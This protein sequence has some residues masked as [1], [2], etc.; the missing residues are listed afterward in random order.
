MESLHTLRGHLGEVGAWVGYHFADIGP[1]GSCERIPDAGLQK[2]MIL[3]HPQVERHQTDKPMLEAANTQVS[4][5]RRVQHLKAL[6]AEQIQAPASLAMCYMHFRTTT[7]RGGCLRC[8]SVEQ[9]RSGKFTLARPRLHWTKLWHGERCCAVRAVTPSRCRI[10]PWRVAFS[11]RVV[12]RA[13]RPPA[14]CG[15]AGLQVA[16]TSAAAIVCCLQSQR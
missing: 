3:G 9:S 1:V 14:G 7:R 4:G 12:A 6:A 2:I 8:R 15:G 13:Q 11:M 16:G 10:Q 5:T